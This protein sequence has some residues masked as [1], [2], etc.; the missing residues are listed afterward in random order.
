MRMTTNHPRSE[1]A[2]GFIMGVA[3]RKI[4]ALLQHRLKSY[5]ITPEQ[6]S[7]LNQIDLANGL[8][9]KE[10]AD[11]TG[12]DKP[13]TT[14]IIDLLESKSLIYKQPGL[15]DRRSFLVYATERGKE[16]IRETA[17]IE[18]SVTEEV[19]RIMSGEEYTLLMELLQRINIHFSD[20]HVVDGEIEK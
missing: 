3:Y 1:L 9:Q 18:Q 10:I 4:A 2:V 19:K 20:P 15:Q 7:V 14:R 8:I 5:E 11:R 13:T 12:K 16:L 17:P 6:W